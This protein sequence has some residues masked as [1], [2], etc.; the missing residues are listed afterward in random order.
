[1]DTT[2]YNRFLYAGGKGLCPL[3][4]APR[5]GDPTQRAEFFRM[6]VSEAPEA[7]NVR[8]QLLR[9][10]SVAG[11]DIMQ[12]IRFYAFTPARAPAEASAGEAAERPIVL[13]RFNDPDRSPAIV[14][15]P[16]GRGNVLLYC[17]TANRRWTDWP[18]Y[19]TDAFYVAAM[20]DMARFLARSQDPG[21]NGPVG[22]PFEMPVPDALR[23]ARAVLSRLDVPGAAEH[24]WDPAGERLRW[25]DTARAGAYAVVFTRLEEPAGEVLF[26][27]NA[28]ADEGDLAV[29]GRDAL[30]A[31]AGDDYVYVQ[32]RGDGSPRAL[33]TRPAREYWV[34]A[35]AA[36]LVL[37]ALE[38]FLAQRFGHYST[39]E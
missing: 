2:F 11:V 21:L 19:G 39:T 8:G 6:A 32:R 13:A 24:E 7:R 34:W 31:V 27:R 3:P 30:D 17:T 36:M 15:R 9:F 1:V 18:A 5:R 35:L 12:Y 20:N 38:T 33:W 22:Q 37:M 25:D 10:A 29:G 14:L 26:A 4:L 28:D 16:F 23:R